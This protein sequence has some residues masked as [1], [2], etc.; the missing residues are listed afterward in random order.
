VLSFLVSFLVISTSSRAAEI[1][2]ALS[3]QILAE[4]NLAPNLDR[5]LPIIL[6]SALTVVQM[7]P[8][9][10]NENNLFKWS[11]NG[12]ILTGKTLSIAFSMSKTPLIA[13]LLANSSSSNIDALTVAPINVTDKTMPILVIL[14]V[15]RIFYEPDGREHPYGFSKLV[16]ALAHEIYGNV[17]HFLEINI[18]GARPQTMG[19]QADHERRTFRAS[20]LFLGGVRDSE[21]FSTLPEHLRKGLMALF[22]AE[23]KAYKSWQRIHG[24]RAPDPACEAILSQFERV[25]H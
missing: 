11:A 12:E 17:Q 16:L 20:L 8:P 18:D 9:K 13:T 24:S 19:D 23:I 21:K 1:R 15:D 25:R 4:S 2:P 3:I 7:F 22:P 14:L 5:E 10:G 6:R